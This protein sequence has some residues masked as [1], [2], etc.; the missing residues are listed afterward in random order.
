MAI[1]LTKATDAKKVLKVIPSGDSAIDWDASYS[2][3]GDLEDD[4]DDDKAVDDSTLPDVQDVDSGLSLTERK[5]RKYRREHDLTKLRFKQDDLPTQFVLAHPHRVDV[6]RKVRELSGQIYTAQ[7]GGRNA[8]A[9]RDMFTSIFHNF[10]LGKE[11]G[12][13]GE[14]EPAPRANGRVTDE[15][16][17]MLEDAEV[18]MEINN[19]FM[20]V[21]NED[22][23]K[24]AAKAQRA[25][26]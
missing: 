21:Y 11:E 9:E 7:A 17:Q 3:P 10:Y 13:S 4:D 20:R 5:Q 8:K 2:E 12:F 19:A 22:R 6:A 1:K 24:A 15:Y 16:L 18:F 14:R 26:K 25:G 23:T